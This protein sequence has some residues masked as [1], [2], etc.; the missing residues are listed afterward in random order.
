VILELT[1]DRAGAV[2]D[3][4][5]F[6]VGAQSLVDGEAVRHA[7][8]TRLRDRHQA[9]RAEAVL[10][11][12]RRRDDRAVTPCLQA[13]RRRSVGQLYVEAAAY[14]ANSKLQPALEELRSAGW[15]FSPGLLDA[16]LERCDPDRQA[17]ADGNRRAAFVKFEKRLRRTRSGYQDL[18]VVL[19]VDPEDYFR[20][21]QLTIGPGASPDQHATWDWD[22]L[23]ARA[24]ND[25]ARAAELVLVDMPLADIGAHE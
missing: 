8:A 9:C 13:L 3:W 16:A 17:A 7:L 21:T 11:L 4:A 22:N 6:A 1:A 10:G 24:G 12:A 20:P 19:S 5:C 14:L 25:P 2:R 18:A 15:N 23:L